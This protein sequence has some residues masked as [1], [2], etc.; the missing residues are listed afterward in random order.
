MSE[1]EIKVLE[2]GS[3][4]QLCGSAEV[5]PG[6]C[7]H[8]AEQRGGRVDEMSLTDKVDELVPSVARERGPASI[9]P[10]SRAWVTL[11]LVVI[12][13]AILAL[14]FFAGYTILSV[15][16]AIAGFGWLFIAGAAKASDD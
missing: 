7:G 16:A 2:A 3:G 15:W 14:L 1:V 9:R 13:A 11:A 6:S 12:F 10:M 8:A 5:I 4:V